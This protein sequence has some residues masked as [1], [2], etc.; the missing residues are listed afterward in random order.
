MRLFANQSVQRHGSGLLAAAVIGLCAVIGTMGPT[1][2]ANSSA[3]TFTQGMVNEGL[4]IL[5]DKS[6]DVAARRARFHQFV[7]RNA[8]ARKTALFALGQYSRGV[9]EPVVEQFVVA[10][11]DYVTAIYELRLEERKD[12]NLK[13]TGSVENKV[14]D[15]T[16]NTEAAGSRDPVK[17]GFRLIGSGGAYKV[18]DVQ[19]AGIWI[20]VEQRDQFASILSKNKGDVPA[21]ITHL[22][23]QTAHMRGG[24]APSQ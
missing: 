6:L 4:G 2:A 20:S 13:V 24:E 5:R 11:R 10:F 8:D 23:T 12:A 22:I 14:N 15:V 18:V 17:I 19:V 21:L 3:E 9:A 16:V 7:A 1:R